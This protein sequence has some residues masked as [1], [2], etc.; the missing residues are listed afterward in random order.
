MVSLLS[1]SP[2]EV[3]AT[4]VKL[5]MMLH[6]SYPLAFTVAGSTLSRVIS[7]KSYPSLL[8]GVIL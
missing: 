1:P 3:T 5:Y 7:G 4:A 8:E 2:A 6:T